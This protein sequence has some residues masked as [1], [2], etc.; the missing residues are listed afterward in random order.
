MNELILPEETMLTENQLIVSN[1][2]LKKQLCTE[3]LKS[4]L[5]ENETEVLYRIIKQ[6]KEL[7]LKSQTKPGCTLKHYRCK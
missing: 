2:E 4:K 7:H 6:L 3:K 5:L 1:R